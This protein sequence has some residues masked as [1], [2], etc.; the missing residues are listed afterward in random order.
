[1]ASIS[2]ENSNYGI[3]HNF[4]PA[5]A[6]IGGEYVIATSRE[7]L[8]DIIDASRAQK[9]KPVDGGN[10]RIADA[11]TISMPCLVALLRE[12]AAEL[13]AKRMLEQDL[14]RRQARRDIDA[15]LELLDHGQ[16]VRF[17]SRMTERGP[18]AS[19]TLTMRTPERARTGKATP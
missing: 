14:P 18:E 17:E 6:V 5:I 1:M 10:D 13:T 2:P 7:L 8:H 15:I 9:D 11:W 4:A 3:R 16:E 19:L 12:N